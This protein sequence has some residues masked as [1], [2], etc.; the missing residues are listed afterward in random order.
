MPDFYD[1]YLIKYHSFMSIFYKYVYIYIYIIIINKY[2]VILI[3]KKIILD[4]PSI[5]DRTM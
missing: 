5:E 3:I 4:Y 1:T 2:K